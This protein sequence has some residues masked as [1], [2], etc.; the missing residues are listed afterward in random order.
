MFKSLSD[1]MKNFS[2][3]KHYSQKRPSFQKDS[4]DFLS[5]I[6]CWPEIVGERLAKHTMPLK[7]NNG[8]LTILTN[9]SAFSQQLS[10]MDNILKKKIIQKFPSLT[11]KIKKIYFQANST[12][13]EQKIEILNKR[14]KN[15][16]TKLEIPHKFSPTYK[17]LYAL[18][19]E[20]FSDID[21]EE[22]KQQFISIYIQQHSLIQEG[23]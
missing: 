15:Q 19:L 11:G 13:F 6:E 12:H 22:L 18:A 1:V 3:G 8:Y 10:F 23:P 20:E 14:K 17:K 4:F 16:S 7:N 2:H 9:H 21:D 5:L